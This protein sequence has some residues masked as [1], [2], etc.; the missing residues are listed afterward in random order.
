MSSSSAGKWPLLPAGTV[1]QGLTVEPDGV[2]WWQWL[3]FFA[4]GNVIA[5]YWLALALLNAHPDLKYKLHQLLVKWGLRKAQPAKQPVHSSSTA[6]KDA[7]EQ[8][9][10][11][12]SVPTTMQKQ[13][14]QQQ[15][16]RSIEPVTSAGA[17]SL[18]V[19]AQ[20]PASPKV[21]T[22]QVRQ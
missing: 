20:Q 8:L 1:T 2:V 11:L 18:V 13:A 12:I 19:P 17:P 15:Q 10:P 5:G 7:A 22:L 21:A 14:S 4:L 9:P 16:A 3:T 6:S